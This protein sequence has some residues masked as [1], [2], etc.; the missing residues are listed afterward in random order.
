MNKRIKQI[1]L[2]GMG[3]ALYVVLSF[4]MKIPL[5]SHIQTDLGYV[6]FGVFLALMGPIAAIVGILGCLLE[7]LLFSGWVPAGWMLGQAFIGIICGTLYKKNKNVIVNIII[8]II[9]VFIGIGIIKTLVECVLFN[10]PLLVKIPK[11]LIAAT[12]DVVP[13]I[14]GYVIALKTPI[15]K[16]IR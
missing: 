8:T 2:L 15:K 6:A 16:F 5:I 13:M 9:A 7:S 4:T 12:A 11:N 1:A 14:V 10:I 3:I